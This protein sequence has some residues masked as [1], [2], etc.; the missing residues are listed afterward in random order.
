PG[1]QPASASSTLAVSRTDFVSTCGQNI[2]APPRSPRS[3]PSEIRPRD[4]LRP[5]KPHSLEW[6]RMQPQE[7]VPCATGT[8]PDA[9]AAAGPPLD[10][11]T[12]CSRSHGFLVGP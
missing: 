2:P 8:M 9:P 12:E 6:I 11:P 3:G 1:I 5:T 4:G 10:P 7:S